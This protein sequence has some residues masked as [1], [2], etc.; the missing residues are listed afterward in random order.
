MNIQNAVG[1]DV[2]ASKFFICWYSLNNHLIQKNQKKVTSIDGV[3]EYL[4]LHNLSSENSVIAIDAPLALAKKCVKGRGCEF[5]LGISGY[6]LTPSKGTDLAAWAKS[7]MDLGRKLV[8]DHKFKYTNEENKGNLLEV[9]PSIIFKRLENFGI[10]LPRLWIMQKIPV[11][12]KRKEGKE[13]R[14]KILFEKFQNQKEK[15]TRLSIDHVDALIA[16]WTVEQFLGKM[17]DRF[18]NSEEGY[19]FVPK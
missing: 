18:G 9:H 2:G 6:F 11:N 10:K 8:K 17:I 12:K 5:E 1:I 4:H 7:G 13:H 16:A 19:I 15:I 14:K 3:I